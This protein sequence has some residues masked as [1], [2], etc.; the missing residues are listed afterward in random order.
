MSSV[1]SHVLSSVGCADAPP[2]PAA[3][4]SSL[5]MWSRVAASMSSQRTPR[6]LRVHPS[7]CAF[8]AASSRQLRMLNRHLRPGVLAP[9]LPDPLRTSA[10]LVGGRLVAA[11][12]AGHGGST[13]ARASGERVASMI[14]RFRY[15]PR[16]SRGDR[17]RRGARLHGSGHH[18][19]LGSAQSHV[20]RLLD[21]GR[22]AAP[23]ETREAPRRK[24]SRRRGGTD[25]SVGVPRSSDARR[26]RRDAG[27]G[28][29]GEARA[30]ASRGRRGDDRGPRAPRAP[31]VRAGGVPRDPVAG[32]A[33][34]PRG[35]GRRARFKKPRALDRLPA[36][37]NTSG[38]G[39]DRP[40]GDAPCCSRRG[41]ARVV[42]LRGSEEGG[43]RERRSR[44][45]ARAPRSAAR[46][47]RARD[48]RVCPTLPWSK[49][50]VF[51]S[52]TRARAPSAF[53]QALRGV[54]PAGRVREGA[55]GEIT[56]ANGVR[57]RGRGADRARFCR[58]E[59]APRRGQLGRITRD[60]REGNASN[61]DRIKTSCSTV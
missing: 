23:T 52:A 47:R 48:P 28:A 37:E 36:C 33:P 1:S 34:P 17:R 30:G 31:R 7:T 5:G 22:C 39:R 26:G 51:P 55:I 14:W 56:D 27:G 40:P 18:F 60:R 16:T 24:D 11:V 2:D 38:A 9:V 20:R 49:I 12:E 29:R 25:V 15:L 59:A 19:S 6:R 57:T 4:W 44:A 32:T 54:H 3:I 45:R 21:R 42:G 13:R 43:G 8:G 46:T 61:R 41:F 50:E 10:A 58:A 53:V 35:G